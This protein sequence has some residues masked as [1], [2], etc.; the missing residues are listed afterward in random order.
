MQ[1]KYKSMHLQN[2]SIQLQIKSAKT[3]L[4][5]DIEASGKPF[6]LVQY[7]PTKTD[8]H[9]PNPICWHL[10]CVKFYPASQAWPD[11]AIQG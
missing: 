6:I 8:Q 4:D 11:R 10:L 7:H 9:Q 5:E 2:C 3:L 1:T